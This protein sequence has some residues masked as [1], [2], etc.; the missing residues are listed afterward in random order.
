MVGLGLESE[1]TG[2]QVPTVS[3][4]VTINKLFICRFSDIKNRPNGLKEHS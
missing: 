4:K 3:D 1:T 2:L